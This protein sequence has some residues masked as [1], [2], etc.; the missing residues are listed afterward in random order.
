MKD[1]EQINL[2]S[3]SFGE[4]GLKSEMDMALEGTVES[5]QDYTGV[6]CSGIGSATCQYGCKDGC[7]DSGKTAPC[8]PSCV[9]GCSA[10]CKPSCQ[11]GNK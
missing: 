7:K 6:G 9:E 11:P 3:Q 8:Q 4:D 5:Q 1:F 2:D 10:G